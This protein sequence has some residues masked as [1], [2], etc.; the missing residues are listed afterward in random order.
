MILEP[1]GM[2][3]VRIEFGGFDAMMLAAN[4]T[5]KPCEVALRAIG[6]DTGNA[7]SR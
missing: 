3:C 1:A 5:S 7:V 2:G 4:H 6:V